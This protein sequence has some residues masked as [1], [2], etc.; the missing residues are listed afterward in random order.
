MIAE[1]AAERP[2][3]LA[4]A[5]LDTSG[6]A[7]I[8]TLANLER[9]QWHPGERWS[10]RKLIRHLGGIDALLIEEQDPVGRVDDAVCD[11]SESLKLVIFA[12]R[13]P[14]VDLGAATQQGILVCNAPGMNAAAVADLTVAFIIMC[15]RRITPAVAG[16]GGWAEEAGDRPMEWVY[17]NFTGFELA[18]RTVGLIGLGAI[19]AETARRLS[20]FGVT[21]IGHDPLVS[22]EAARRLGVEPVPLDRLLRESDFVSLHAPVNDTTKG[23]LGVAE[24]RAMKST[25]YLVNTA[26]AALVDEAA[27]QTALEEQW[28]AGAALDVFHEEPVR[29][30][31][32][33]L[34]HER[35][36]ATPHIG[37]AS[38][39]QVR[40]QSEL[41]TAT[42][43]RF[44][45]GEPLPNLV[46]PEVLDS[47]HLRWTARPGG[48]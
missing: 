17:R 41:Y 44:L 2:R 28:I 27:L 40:H 6:A 45:C 15:A 5:R 20:G 35:V 31:H 43:K 1:R 39:D 25:A 3:V 9:A 33:L 14:P 11:A 23:L 29:P 32:P 18:G 26:R 21:L 16:I 4:A 24:L 19:G 7:E 37:G 22:G 47:P 48:G 46:N 34:H 36:I 30:D 42:L 8:R 12:G 10:S 38:S 13:N